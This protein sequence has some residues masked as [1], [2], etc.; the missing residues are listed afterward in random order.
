MLPPGQSFRHFDSHGRALSNRSLPKKGNFIRIDP[1][2]YF[3]GFSKVIP[4]LRGAQRVTFGEA[5][6]AFSQITK[7]YFWVQIQSVGSESG[8]DLDRTQVVVRPSRD[9]HEPSKSE[10]TK[11]MFSSG[12]TNVFTIERVGSSLR[13]T[14]EGS[15]EVVNLDAGLLPQERVVNTASAAMAWGP[16]VNTADGLSA[17]YGLQKLIWGSF[18]SSAVSPRDLGSCDLR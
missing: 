14:V 1:G 16:I 2:F 9:P 13:L 12:A 10:V 15:N 17:G 18:L 8:S 11:H 5:Q 3:S 4:E 6:R 7:K